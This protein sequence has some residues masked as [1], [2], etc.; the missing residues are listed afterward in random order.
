LGQTPLSL[1]ISKGNFE[2]GELL[3]FAGANPNT[4]DLLGVTSMQYLLNYEGPDAKGSDEMFLQ[5]LKS[6]VSLNDD[7]LTKG[8]IYSQLLNSGRNNR[9]CEVLK[10]EDVKPSSREIKQVF[11]SFCRAKILKNSNERYLNP[12]NWN[13]L[14]GEEL[15]F[16]LSRLKSLFVQME[17][18]KFPKFSV[19]VLTKKLI[20]QKDQ[21]GRTFATNSIIYGNLKALNFII[22]NNGDL[23]IADS[24]KLR[25]I[26]HLCLS[27]S[28]D[29]ESI[30]KSLFNSLI[31]WA[32]AK[33]QKPM[34]VHPFFIEMNER[35]AVNLD[36]LIEK[37]ILGNK[38]NLAN[39]L[40]L[41]GV[42]PTKE[43]K[44]LLSRVLMRLI[45]ERD[46][47]FED[48][49]ISCAKIKR[50]LNY[51][52]NP[53][54]LIKGK[55]PLNEAIKMKKNDIAI[56]LL[57]RG[58]KFKLK[59]KDGMNAVDYLVE[60]SLHD[61]KGSQNLAQFKVNTEKFNR[62]FRIMIDKGLEPKS[63][64]ECTSSGIPLS[65]FYMERA[66]ENKNVPFIVNFIE[67]GYVPGE[68]M[69]KRK[70]EEFMMKDGGVY[71]T[72]ANLNQ[73]YKLLGGN[74]LESMD[75]VKEREKSEVLGSSLY[76]IAMGEGK[77]IL[78]SHIEKRLQERGLK[79]NFDQ[80]D[81]LGRTP[82]LNSIYKGSIKSA[83][84][85]ISN[86]PSGV[87]YAKEDIFG[88]NCF[89]YLCG[90]L[91]NTDSYRIDEGRLKVISTDPSLEEHNKIKLFDKV[92]NWIEKSG[93]H[94]N[95]AKEMLSIKKLQEYF[96]IAV[97]AENLMA[98]EKLI[99]LG[100]LGTMEKTIEKT[101]LEMG[102]KT[103]GEIDE[104]AF[105]NTFLI[106]KFEAQCAKEGNISLL[107]KIFERGVSL[108][109]MDFRVSFSGETPLFQAIKNNKFKTALWLLDHFVNPNHKDTLGRTPLRVLCESPILEKS[110]G[111]Q[112]YY[113]E[114]NPTK[115]QE[116]LKKLLEKT[117]GLDEWGGFAKSYIDAAIDSGNLNTAKTL[118]SIGAAMN[119]S[120]ESS[121]NTKDYPFLFDEKPPKPISSLSGKDIL[122]MELQFIDGYKG[123]SN[124][125]YLT[126]LFCNAAAMSNQK[127]LKY[128]FSLDVDVDGKDVEGKS[129]IFYGAAYGD[130]EVLKYLI[131]K[132]SK[133]NQVDSQGKT[134]LDHAIENGKVENAI[135][136]M[137]FDQEIRAK[138]ENLHHL[139]NR[140]ELGE[141]GLSY[142]DGKNLQERITKKT[143][144]L[145]AQILE[146]NGDNA[147]NHTIDRPQILN[148]DSD[149][150]RRFNKGS[151]SRR[152]PDSRD[153][154]NGICLNHNRTINMVNASRVARTMI[155]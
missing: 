29:D 99:D 152:K 30:S 11:L 126:Q 5:L 96:E 153:I 143:G 83:L 23:S 32:R 8:S 94:N 45:K 49:Q 119:R 127:E 89:H 52:A 149:F 56:L 38:Y 64:L 70:L 91:E 55:R 138:E 19:S 1:A 79:L 90:S 71:L 92:V 3:L 122:K 26:D 68:L 76:N 154:R 24:D 22:Q 47:N 88:E 95:K 82:F 128:L 112:I 43:G 42:R 114:E 60:I 130:Q 100:V 14:S 120:E 142:Q 147:F 34:G 109:L 48:Y 33:N 21:H 16:G 118:I 103:G 10:M 87:D 133:V 51:G 136:L 121:F 31:D 6:G 81:D 111:G 69:D 80:T 84:H 46:E 66:L 37:S 36:G 75:L 57:E 110:F 85:I 73:S 4:K 115:Y 124:S 139:V 78:A 146:K 145:F 58:G 39:W 17:K 107:K 116:L 86:N 2:L 25:A 93:V 125:N 117:E 44:N 140:I 13:A 63:K 144:I 27:K 54:A 41:D 135:L 113:E 97:H 50:L 40:Y 67:N 18:Q 155:L 108:D 98:A 53:N 62:L 131:S 65:D 151:K 134:P 105:H 77:F 35:L 59:D 72:A 137:Q 101:Y 15:E 141:G 9:L 150:N 20:D 74:L 61:D 123:I 7:T 102:K 132:N 129:A 12:S 106:S 104:E 148:L 28:I